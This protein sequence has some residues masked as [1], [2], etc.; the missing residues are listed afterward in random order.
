MRL[1]N[2]LRALLFTGDDA[3]RALPAGTFTDPRLTARTRP[4]ARRG[5]GPR[6]ASRPVGPEGAEGA[7]LLVNVSRG[8]DRAPSPTTTSAVG[9]RSRCRCPPADIVRRVSRKPTGLAC[10]APSAAVLNRWPTQTMMFTAAEKARAGAFRF[11]TDR[12]DYLAAHTLIRV[13]VSRVVGR[14]MRTVRLESRCV[15]C[16]GPHGLPEILGHV[17]HWVSLSHTRGHVGAAIA[18]GPVGIDLEV[19]A[20]R[21]IA[22]VIAHVTSPAERA[23][24]AATAEPAETFLRLWVRKEVLVKSGKGD[25]DQTDALDV[26]YLNL[27]ERTGAVTRGRL[28][29]LEFVEWSYPTDDQTPVLVAAAAVEPLSVVDYTRLAAI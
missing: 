28:A 21:Q 20:G 10:A 22:E 27:P 16:G 13:L 15:R 1:I 5:A 12:L 7:K 9:H 3:D 24:I 11:E 29:E 19:A 18:S 6:A 8:P 26:S 14:S 23:L 4:S 2:R 25:L 17:G